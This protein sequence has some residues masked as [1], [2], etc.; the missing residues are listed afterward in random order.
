MIYTEDVIDFHDKFGLPIG[1]KPKIPSDGRI[2]LRDTLITEEYIELTNALRG[3]DIEGIADGAADL[4]YV[5]IGTCLEYGIDIDRVWDE[6]HR[7][8]MNKVGGETREDGKILKPE[9]WEPPNI[10][11]ALGFPID[12]AGYTSFPLEWGG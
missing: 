9:G 10:K 8:N 2:E 3:G 6:V 4:I 1:S 5:I 11:K 12:R 7:A